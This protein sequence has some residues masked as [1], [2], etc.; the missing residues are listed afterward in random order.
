M[1]NYRRQS[2]SVLVLVSLLLCTAMP[3]SA[4]RRDKDK[5]KG[6]TR[7]IVGVVL[8]NADNPIEGAVV[9]LK[10]KK[11]LQIRSFITREGG[12]FHFHSLSMEVDY[13]LKADSNGK[14]SNTRALSVFDSRKQASMNLKI[15]K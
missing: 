14:V 7:S 5:E 6:N 9:Q 15:D 3:G 12:K 8:D 11:S 1:S 10:D 13:E 2:V 4:Q